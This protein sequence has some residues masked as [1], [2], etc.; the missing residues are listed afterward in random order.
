M[1]WI[2]AAGAVTAHSLSLA[3]G[4]RHCNAP[5][6]LDAYANITAVAEA[7]NVTGATGGVGSA[8]VRALVS[9]GDTAMAVARSGSALGELS[10][11]SDRVIPIRMEL[12]QLTTCRRSF[13]DMIRQPNTVLGFGIEDTTSPQSTLGDSYA[14]LTR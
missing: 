11:E 1:S 3:P 7:V 13:S 4:L 10:V 2:S 8:V 5:E 9:R 14:S 12:C 6:A